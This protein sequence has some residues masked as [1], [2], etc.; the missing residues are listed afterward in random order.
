MNFL[1]PL[2]GLVGASVVIAIATD[3]AACQENVV[4]RVNGDVVTSREVEREVGRVIGRRKVDAA[5]KKR[6]QA[7]TL[8]QVIDR[9]LVHA[10]L[11]R[12]GRGATPAEIDQLAQRTKKDL[13]ERKRDWAAYLHEQGLTDDEWRRETA[14]RIAWSRYVADQFDD[15]ALTKYFERRRRDFDGTKIH[16]R[17]LLLRI[18]RDEAAETTMKLVAKATAI[19][20]DI[21]AGKLTFDQA[22]RQD[23]QAPTKDNAGDLGFVT[24]HGDHVEA[25]SKAVFALEKGEI[26]P[27]VVTPFGVHLIQCVE[28]KPGKKTLDDVREDVL[29]AA[30]A[31]LFRQRAASERKTARIDYP[32]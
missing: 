27:P 29:A 4:A 24:R 20:D 18:D 16:V 28:I 22:V 25:F 32:K 11:E 12:T 1:A 17:H 23:S 10:W 26:S 19:R 8:E 21:A 13:A 14:W 3:A 9:R 2:L 7:G 5:T 30:T 15:A 31:E 6:I